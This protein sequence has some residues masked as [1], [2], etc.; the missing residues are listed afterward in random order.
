MGKKLSKGRLENK[1]DEKNIGKNNMGE[2]NQLMNVFISYSFSF[3]PV[4]CF[5]TIK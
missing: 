3:D 5:T 2:K 4:V 1:D